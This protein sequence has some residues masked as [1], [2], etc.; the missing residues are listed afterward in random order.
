MVIR[1]SLKSRLSISSRA[2]A[3][4]VAWIIVLRLNSV[5]WERERITGP[6]PK[7]IVDMFAEHQAK[8]GYPL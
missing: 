7:D 5:H 8:K 1:A 6:G 4:A 2:L 3:V